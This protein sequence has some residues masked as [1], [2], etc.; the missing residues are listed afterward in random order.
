[1]LKNKDLNTAETIQI[2]LN[3]GGLLKDQL[4]YDKILSKSIYKQVSY[5]LKN[6]I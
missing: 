6:L 3:L 1:M 2:K 5:L 4:I